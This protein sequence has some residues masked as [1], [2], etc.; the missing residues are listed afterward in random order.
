MVPVL[1]MRWDIAGKMPDWVMM[2]RELQKAAAMLT[3]YVFR[4]RNANGN[5]SGIR[6]V[7]QAE[8]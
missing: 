2:D 4:I 3:A 5:V 7:Q 8:R 1:S 6:S